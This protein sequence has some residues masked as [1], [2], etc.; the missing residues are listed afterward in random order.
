MKKRILCYG[1]S[2]TWG[3][4]PEGQPDGFHMRFPEDV[5]WP[6]V[7]QNELGDG[8]AVVEEGLNGRTTAFDQDGFRC[9]NGLTFLESS[10]LTH[11]PVDVVVLML[12]TNDLKFHICG[13]PEASA[14]SLGLL[15]EEITS[16]LVGPEGSVPKIL[17]LSPVHLGRE[18]VD[19]PFSSD[20]KGQETIEASRSLAP[21]YKQQADKVGADF[22]DAADHADTGR[23][24]VHLT[25]DGHGRL[26]A[27]VAEKIRSM[28]D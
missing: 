19:G 12:G 28:L 24:G 25:A 22:L 20:F 5:R 15:L 1:D 3:Y 21:L 13:D 18:I 14:R 10:L 2:N 6:G 17:V 4:M 16:T 7:L 8:Y 11:E 9:R 23:D 26:G 27:A